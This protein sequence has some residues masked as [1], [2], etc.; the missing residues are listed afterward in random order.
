MLSAQKNTV[1][2]DSQYDKL[3]KVYSVWICLKPP[4]RLENT[5]TKFHTVQT[6]I[7]GN[8][9]EKPGNYDLQT[10]IMLCLGSL[11]S[12]DSKGILRFLSVLFSNELRVDEKKLILEK[13]YSLAMTQNMQEEAKRMFNFSDVLVEE[14]EARGEARGKAI[15]LENGIL[16]SLK[17]LMANMNLTV[18][19]AMKAL[20][21]PEEDRPRYLEK[22][23]SERQPQ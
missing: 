2:S 8:V 3:R 21:I 6:N 16:T 17:N 13:E 12:P 7:I 9:E 14:S 5:I 22:L 23:A 18:Q 19:E 15:G 10:I 11:D 20:G 4:K 1:F